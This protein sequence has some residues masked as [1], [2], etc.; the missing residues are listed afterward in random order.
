MA[1]TSLHAQ[2]YLERSGGAVLL[3]GTDRHTVNSGEIVRFGSVRCRISFGAGHAEQVR[4][5]AGSLGLV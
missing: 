3:H 2:T 1:R 4:L 5:L